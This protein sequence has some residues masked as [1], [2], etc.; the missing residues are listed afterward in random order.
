MYMF[1]THLIYM[2]SEYVRVNNGNRFE[3]HKSY[4]TDNPWYD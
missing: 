4:E 3:C 2:V 1:T